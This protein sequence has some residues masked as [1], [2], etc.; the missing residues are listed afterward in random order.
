MTCLKA[1]Y[2]YSCQETVSKLPSHQDTEGKCLL[3]GVV[4]SMIQ[5]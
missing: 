1:S 3:T 4:F 5:H 2:G